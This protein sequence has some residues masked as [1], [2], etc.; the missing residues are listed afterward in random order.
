MRLLRLFSGQRTYRNLPQ[1]TYRRLRIE[2]LEDRSMYAVA[3][4]DFASPPVGPTREDPPPP[5]AELAGA[6]H[7]VVHS[8]GAS[9]LLC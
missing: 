9:V 2:P 1:S 4:M 8:L 3:G 7:D 5:T 6:Y